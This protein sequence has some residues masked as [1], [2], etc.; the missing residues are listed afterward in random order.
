MIGK[1]GDEH[2]ADEWR[3]RLAQLRGKKPFTDV[4]DMVCEVIEKECMGKFT[5]DGWR[6]WVPNQGVEV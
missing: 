3:R 6:T 4:S 2:A 1:H 5:G